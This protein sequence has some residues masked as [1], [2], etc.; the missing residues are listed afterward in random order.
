M[1]SEVGIANAALDT[2][3]GEHIASLTEDSRNA[4]L[5]N[6]CYVDARD[7]ELEAHP[8]MF[9][10]KRVTLS[11]DATDPNDTY[12]YQ[13]TLPVGCLRVLLPRRTNLDWS[14]EGG[15]ILTNDGTTIDVRYIQQ[16]TD[17][18]AMPSLF[19]AAL[20]CRIGMKI[21]QPL[22]QSTAKLEAVAQMRKLLIAEAKK[23]NAI[24]QTPQEEPDDTWLAARR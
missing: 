20:A 3:G 5:I 13:F 11:P 22:T 16:I 24:Q 17:P 4:R 6:A 21:C 15:K 2:V 12:D 14:I 23:T 7:E 19:R 9:A 1:A 10:R 18:N 8:W